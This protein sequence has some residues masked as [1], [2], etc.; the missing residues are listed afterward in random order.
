MSENGT[1][2]AQEEAVL[3]PAGEEPRGVR[4]ADEYRDPAERVCLVGEQSS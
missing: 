3:P 1:H 2:A 4:D